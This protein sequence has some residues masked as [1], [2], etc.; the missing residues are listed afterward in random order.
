MR[1][2][3]KKRIIGNTN[4]IKVLLLGMLMSVLLAG[5]SMVR[6]DSQIYQSIQQQTQAFQQ[7]SD[8]AKQDSVVYLT[9]KLYAF[10]N[11]MKRVT[12]IV[13][14]VSILI[15]VFLLLMVQNDQAIR[16]KAIVIFIIAIPLLMFGVTYGMNWLVGTFL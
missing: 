9:E 1:E 7:N 5:C 13:V 10:C 2:K 6:T 15:G 14:P 12:P 4:S 8:K 16:K 3:L 11:R